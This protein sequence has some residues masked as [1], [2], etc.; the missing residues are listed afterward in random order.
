MST[1]LDTWFGN[2]SNE[3]IPE[4]SFPEKITALLDNTETK[5]TAYTHNNS[6][7]LISFWTDGLKFDDERTGVGIVSMLFSRQ[8]QTRKFYL[9]NTK[10]IIDAE[11]Y[12]IDQELNLAHRVGNS[13]VL[14]PSQRTR[15]D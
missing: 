1:K 14:K 13:K 6:T 11:L 8:W 12:G 2:E 15:E 10:Q 4:A 7:D 3:Q 9:V 5:T